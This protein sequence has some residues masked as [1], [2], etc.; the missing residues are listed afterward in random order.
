MAKRIAWDEIVDMCPRRTVSAIRGHLLEIEF[1]RGSKICLFGADNPDSLRGIGLGRFVMDEYA[2]MHERTFPE[3]VRPMLATTKGEGM[4]IGT[5]K[6]YNHFYELYQK[7]LTGEHPDW[8]AMQS[9]TLEGGLVPPAE[10]E[11]ARR[12][13]SER[14]FRQ[15]FEASFESMSARVYYAFDRKTNV[16]DQVQEDPELDVLIG[17]DFNIS[18][19]M[20]A[21]VAHRVADQ[22]H[23]FDEIFIPDGN[24]EELARECQRRYGLVKIRGVM[25]RRR[26]IAYPD[27]TGKRRQTSSP[28][29]QTDHKILRDNGIE[30]RTPYAPY[31]TED[32]INTTN[33]ALR[34]ASGIV[35]TFVSP[36]CKRL[37]TG[38]EGLTY[39]GD[40]GEPDKSGN[41]DHITDA[42]AYLICMELPMVHRVIANEELIL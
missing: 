38:L 22:I 19:G 20:H 10:I 1:H 17:I 2:D 18:P 33:A 29:G 16:R 6:G 11:A 34:T 42:L 8:F 3:I 32:K 26:L 24:T 21:A 41:L 25:R 4:F 15:E 9:T 5:P 30:V 35:R 31:A 37:I 14:Q 27:P 28:I 7:A 36:K 39:K 13:M 12:E 23:V 40:T